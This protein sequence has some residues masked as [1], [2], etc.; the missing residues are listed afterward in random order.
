MKS[1]LIASLLLV[2]CAEG[3]PPGITASH[4]AICYEDQSDCVHMARA[5]C[6]LGFTIIDQEARREGRGD[7]AQLRFVEHYVCREP[8]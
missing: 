2:S 6:P 3:L 7:T 5:M 1:I 8:K 4:E